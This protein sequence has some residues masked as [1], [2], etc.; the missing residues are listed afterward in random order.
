MLLLLFTL[1]LTEDEEEDTATDVSLFL[2]SFPSGRHID[3]IQPLKK[4][5]LL[6]DMRQTK[7]RHDHSSQKH[8][9]KAVPLF[10]SFPSE[11]K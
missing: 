11:K 1:G 3:N 4:T 6:H 9:D 10:P 2:A 7:I 5:P 8:E